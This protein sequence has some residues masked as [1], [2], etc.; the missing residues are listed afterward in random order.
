MA[1]Q[2]GNSTSYIWHIYISFAYEIFFEICG[3]FYKPETGKIRL[4]YV[5]MNFIANDNEK[6]FPCAANTE[7]KS[8]NLFIDFYCCSFEVTYTQL[9]RTYVQ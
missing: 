1:R 4:Y 7:S 8:Q 3:I 6:I 9:R 5:E 2:A